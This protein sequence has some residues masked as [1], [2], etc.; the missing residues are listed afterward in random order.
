MSMWHPWTDKPGQRHTLTLFD[1]SCYNSIEDIINTVGLKQQYAFVNDILDSEEVPNALLKRKETEAYVSRTGNICALRIKYKNK[2]GFLIPAISWGYSRIPDEKLLSTIQTIFDIFGYEA[3]TPSS[4]SEKILRSA[5]P[6]KTVISR[7]NHNLRMSLINHS[8]GGR[9]DQKELA[10]FY[11]V[12]YAYDI[13]KAYLYYSR[14]VVN[15]FETPCY[16]TRCADWREYAAA[17]LHVRL[18]ARGDGVQPIQIQDRGCMR[19]PLAD[20]T[21]DLWL[22]SDELRD[23]LD[24]GY[25]L[26][27]AL[28]GY[29]WDALSNF[30]EQW[31]DILWEKWQE[32]RDVPEIAK[33]IKTMMVG[34]PGRFLRR[35]EK[36]TLIH[37][38]EIQDGDMPV[39]AN[40]RGNDSPFTEWAIRTEFDLDSAQL[41]PVGSYIIMQ[42]RR[43]IYRAQCAEEA[44]GNV[45]ISSYIDC[46]IFAQPALS[47]EV[48]KG[49]GQYKEEIYKALV[50]E[51]NQ[52]IGYDKSGKLVTRLP[53]YGTLTSEERRRRQERIKELK[54]VQY[55]EE[56]N[57]S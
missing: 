37:I 20:E 42:C 46:V 12:A 15:P 49:M 24:K 25:E 22:W 48:G 53:G 30:M 55:K 50:A 33:I 21:L 51:D 27:E 35:P 7:P 43:E 14:S 45:V 10:T 38:S 54:N 29:T 34:L 40:W 44:K 3:L 39:L 16:H 9:I 4:L 8:P 2:S 57:T 11:P 47:L 1:R 19:A 56:I 18:V 13:I 17:W 26:V 28:E 31:S 41:T 52:F 23:C 36:Y 32:W 5:L 6:K